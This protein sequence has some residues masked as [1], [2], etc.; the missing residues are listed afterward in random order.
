[1]T[2]KILKSLVPVLQLHCPSTQYFVTVPMR[3]QFFFFFFLIRSLWSSVRSEIFLM[4]VILYNIVLTLYS[5]VL[6]IRASPPT[7]PWHAW[8][9]YCQAQC[10]KN[11]LCGREQQMGATLIVRR[12]VWAWN[13]WVR[14][15]FHSFRCCLLLLELLI[16]SSEFHSVGSALLLQNSIFGQSL[17]VFLLY[18]LTNQ[19]PF[20]LYG[21]VL[22]LIGS[23]HHLFPFMDT[24]YSWLA[25]SPFCSPIKAPLQSLLITI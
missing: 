11:P 16:A 8:T 13:L 3:Q 20:S 25:S 15:L 22:F 12:L 6:N 7:S 24:T 9:I 18:P 21:S 5:V 19:H 2:S 14:F 10:Y 4:W 23:F 17:Y 1:M